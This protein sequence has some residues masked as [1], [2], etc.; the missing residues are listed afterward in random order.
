MEK[1]YKADECVVF[2]K[3][4]EAFRGLSNMAAG[5][6]VRVNGSHYET[7]E[8]LYQMCHFSDYSD[9]Q[10]KICGESN[11]VTAKMLSIKYREE[12]IR[13]DWL[14]VREDIMFWCFRLKLAA[15]REKFG[16][17]LESTGDK[18]IVE[19]SREDRFW[20]AVK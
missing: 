12:F 2:G 20:G 5:S 8:H 18:M 7:L 15:N 16:A 11:P 4:H 17:L 19:D 10:S 1:I 6:M 13:K 3:T 14:D 9:I